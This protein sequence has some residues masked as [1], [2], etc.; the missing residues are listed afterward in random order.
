MGAVYLAQDLK[1]GEIMRIQGDGEKAI[2]YFNE[3]LT[4]AREIGNK[5]SEIM[6]LTNMGGAFVIMGE[7]EK[8]AIQL[9]NVIEMIGEAG[10][11]FSLTEA[12]YFLAEALLGQNKITEALAA[13][14]VSLK[15]S[16]KAENQETTA[17][18]WRVLGVDFRQLRRK[19]NHRK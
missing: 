5:S 4:N 19:I 12:H 10:N 2:P 18:A 3:A 15:L 14:K 17:H 6:I 9:Q 16:Q 13:A 11:H 1:L 8:A 7:H